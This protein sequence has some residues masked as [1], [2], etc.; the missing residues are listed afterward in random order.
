VRLSLV[1]RP[2]LA[3]IVVEDRLAAVVAERL[4]QL[5]DALARQPRVLLQEA[6][7]LVLERIEL[8]RPRRALVARRPLAPQRT[9]DS[10]AVVAGAPHD[11]VDRKPVDLLHPPDLR[12]APHVEHR[13]LLASHMTWR[14]SDPRR[15]KPA[16]PQGAF[17]TGPDG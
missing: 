2:D 7:D 3:Q 14:G 6:P 1:E 9:A 16:T 13:L 5:A 10:V 15:T 12:P 11:L 8:R 17:S 4:D